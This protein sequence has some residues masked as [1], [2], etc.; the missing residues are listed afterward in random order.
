M[1]A[2]ISHFGCISPIGDKGSV[3]S[4]IL[5][6]R[7]TGRLR[8]FAALLETM[9]GAP[10][11]TAAGG[12]ECRAFPYTDLRRAAGVYYWL[13]QQD[14]GL[15]R[16]AEPL[17]RDVLAQRLDAALGLTPE[18][19]RG[20]GEAAD[21]LRFRAF[22]A[23]A[24]AIVEDFC[25]PR[26]AF[27]G[28]PHHSYS[29]EKCYHPQIEWIAALWVTMVVAY[30]GA[31]R[32]AFGAAILAELEAA[33]AGPQPRG[34]YWDCMEFI[35]EFSSEKKTLMRAMS[36][37]GFVANSSDL[38]WPETMFLSEVPRLED[39]LRFL[40][41]RTKLFSSTRGILFI[42]IL[43]ALR[44]R[45]EEDPTPLETRFSAGDLLFLVRCVSTDL[46]PTIDHFAPSD[47]LLDR[48]ISECIRSFLVYSADYG[49]QPRPEALAAP[50]CAGA[51]I[52]VVYW[53]KRD[54]LRPWPSEPS[55]ALCE[56]LSIVPRCLETCGNFE[57]FASV[58]PVLFG[59][60]VPCGPD[61]AAAF[62]AASPPPEIEAVDGTRF[63][64]LIQRWMRSDTARFGDDTDTERVAEVAGD[65]LLVWKPWH[66][67]LGASPRYDTPVAE[68]V[69]L[70]TDEFFERG[71]HQFILQRTVSRLLCYLCTEL[72]LYRIAFGMFF[73]ERSVPKLLD[74]AFSYDST[75]PR[76]GPYKLYGST[77]EWFLLQSLND[78]FRKMPA[79]EVAEEQ[80]AFLVRVCE[81]APECFT[82]PAFI[83]DIHPEVCLLASPSEFLTM[84]N[85]IPSQTLELARRT[86]RQKVRRT[87][88]DDEDN[89]DDDGAG[90]ASP[91]G[92]DDALQCWEREV[93]ALTK[94]AGGW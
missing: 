43:M 75:K 10:A 29:G 14:Q 81:E 27:I 52:V 76:P 20:D 74:M 22:R 58:A 13:E 84:R 45:I 8:A 78:V 48:R 6:P 61:D 41:Y 72:R 4:P 50:G 28:R 53:G 35:R 31:R 82:F 71:D 26:T 30:N 92:A 16:D 77:N 90:R 65:A 18:E 67:F 34:S 57:W 88:G 11:S 93:G 21:R 54:F 66:H 94:S 9:S 91:S 37:C 79:S 49:W 12:V 80:L 64:Y 86:A 51:S 59:A 60:T 25:A 55:F 40:C 3:T 39:P 5:E 19:S 63:C 85:L 44:R 23:H 32:W 83:R 70:I 62:P 15:D 87:G 73:G 38:W 42:D 68:V 46:H 47:E 2:E 1:V 33:A 56:P 69:A 89:E 24:R 36:I 7:A 17:E